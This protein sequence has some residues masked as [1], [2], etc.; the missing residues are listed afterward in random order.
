MTPP[1]E[2]AAP[3][4]S[5]HATLFVRLAV[6]AG[7]FAALFTF[8]PMADVW[9]AMSR[10]GWARWL[11]VVAA[12]GAGHAVAAMKWRGLLRAAGTPVDA[13]DAL[14]AHGAGL[15]ANIWLP[16]IIGGDVVRAGWIARRHGLAIPAVA[17]MVDRVLDLLALVLLAAIGAA[18]SGEVGGGAA[19]LLRGAA[20]FLAIGVVGG[21]AVL[22]WLRPEHVP[23]AVRSPAARALEIGDALFRQPGPA[24][25]ALGLSLAVQ[26]LFVC[27]NAT[28]AA[29][30][31][32]GIPLAAWLLAW[33]LAKIAA[34][35]PV[36]LGGL[37]VREA[38]LAGLLLPFGVG[39]ALAVAQGLVWQSVLF[40]FGAV[41][42]AAAVSGAGSGAQPDRPR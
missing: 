36:S 13:V 38:A 30:V 17:G 1:G 9:A 10:T 32:I 6:T 27:L 28:L 12:F 5:R 19:T 29:A 26:F 4:A 2:P 18:W 7:I 23:A 40:G 33:P 25:R 24:L 15:F 8:L 42:G 21:L 34:L 41:A 20:G 11:G 37:G 31:G 14:R 35:A 16:S 22:R 39:G 3:K